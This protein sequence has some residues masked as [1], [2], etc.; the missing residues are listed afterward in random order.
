MATTAK[1]R[2]P[3]KMSPD[4]QTSREQRAARTREQLLYSAA[5][6]VGEFGYRDASIQRITAHAGMALGTF[7]LYFDS[8]QTL[9]DEL[10][11]HY[12]VQMLERVR[13]RA[14]GAK[15]FYEV[16]EIGARVV[17]EYLCENPWFWRVLNE[18]EVEAPQA[19]ASHHREVTRRY[20]KFLQRAKSEG[21]I[22]GYDVDELDTL[23]YLLIAARDYLYLH[24]LAK[25]PQN[26]Q[27]PERAIH[28]YMQFLRHGLGGGK[29]AKKVVKPG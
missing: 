23:A 17:F 3:R 13:E 5:R 27:V 12:G 18:A 9:F 15:G 7:Y 1:K 25:S 29:S 2:T 24:H 4:V 20:N 11:P 26:S 19:W 6:V 21:E 16:E 10:L 8:R 28:T 14:H 22:A